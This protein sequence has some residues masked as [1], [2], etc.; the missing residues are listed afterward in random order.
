[1]GLHSIRMAK[2]MLSDAE[3]VAMMRQTRSTL[4]YVPRDDAAGVS[5][6]P[7]S[8]RANRI[9]ALHF[10]YSCHVRRPRLAQ[11][12]ARC[13]V[14]AGMLSQVNMARFWLWKTRTTCVNL[15]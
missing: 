6:E 11:A 9:E 15:S 2:A 1:M 7:S 14:T 5:A 13:P 3:S 4:D 10:K 8:L 12:A